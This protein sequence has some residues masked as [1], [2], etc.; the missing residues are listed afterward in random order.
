MASKDLEAIHL[1]KVS[2]DSPQLSIRDEGAGT[3]AQDWDAAEEKAL[4]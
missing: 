3:I 4:V 1:E 2:P